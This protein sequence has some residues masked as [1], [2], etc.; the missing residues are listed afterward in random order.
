GDMSSVTDWGGVQ[1]VVSARLSVP[2]PPVA[3][4]PEPLKTI[5]LVPVTV[6]PGSVVLGATLHVLAADLV[7]VNVSGMALPCESYTVELR[8]TALSAPPALFA[9]RL[10]SAVSDVD[11]LPVMPAPIGMVMLV[12]GTVV[13][14]L[15]VSGLACQPMTCRPLDGFTS[16]P[17]MP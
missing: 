7:N 17:S 3:T 14:I 12:A 9:S 11:A 4:L 1:P 6:T 10:P 2:V 13:S 8:L 5:V 16:V 15:P